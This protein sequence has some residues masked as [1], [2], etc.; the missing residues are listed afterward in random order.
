VAL[1][2]VRRACARLSLPQQ[3]AHARV[4][5]GPCAT[6]FGRWSVRHR[7]SELGRGLF[8]SRTYLL[9]V[10]EIAI[11]VTRHGGAIFVGDVRNLALM[12]MFHTWVEAARADPQTPASELRERILASMSL[13]SRLFVA[14]DFFRS[15]PDLVPRVTGVETQLR[16]DSGLTEMSRYRYDAICVSIARPPRRR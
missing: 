11:A 7:D 1:K 3:A 13:E 4:P 10:L 6:S 15:L 12:E 5:A 8:P 16:R 2:N 9:E 14:P